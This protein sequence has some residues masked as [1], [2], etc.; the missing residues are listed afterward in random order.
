MKIV[1]A[2]DFASFSPL[3]RGKR[4]RWLAESIMRFLAV[5]K[6]NR[7]YD[8][9]G[10]YSGADFAARLLE[11]LGINYAI[12]N[13]G[14]L[15]LL[16]EGAFITISN[17]P[18]GGLD[19]I[20]LVDL[21]AGIRDDYKLMVNKILSLVK[22]MHCNFITVT[23]LGGQKIPVTVESISGIRE[24]ITRLQGGHPVGFFPSGAVSDLSLKEMRVRDREWQKSIIRLI[25]DV[26]VPVLPVRFFDGNS[27]FFY[28]LGLMYWKIRLLRLPGELF[29]KHERNIRIGI[30]N[31]ISVEEQMQFKNSGDLG[32]YLRKAVYEMPM[33]ESFIFRSGLNL[34]MT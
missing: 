4:G 6:I 30:G 29:N 27:V 25:H 11:D 5:D 31:L 1:D 17:H 19:G 9:S 13:A 12:G 15:K 22:T 14:R 10:K 3:F 26:R 8:H 2:D 16:P 23:P 33:P 24:T 7:V 32:Q 20:I 34:A 21:M 18:Y 28:F